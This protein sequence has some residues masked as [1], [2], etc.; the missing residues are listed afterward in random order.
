MLDKIRRFLTGDF[1]I[2]AARYV[3]AILLTLLLGS[4]LIMAYGES[5]LTAIHYIIKGSFGSK[6]SIGSTIRY[7]TPC[8]LLAT[9]AA[10][11]F[12]S[13]V[14]N[15]GLE[16]QLYF[17]SLVAAVV[18]YN[19]HLP[20]GIHLVVC[21]L[22]GAL[23]GVIYAL[24]PA[25]LKLLI[26]VDEMVSTLML[27]FIAVSMTDYIV[28][29][30]IIGGNV[31]ES[32]S[33][34]VVTPTIDA[35]AKLPTLIKGITSNYGF[36]IAIVI[37]VIVYILYKYTVLGYE[38]KQ[39]G[40]NIKFAKLGGVNTNKTFLIIFIVSGFIAGLCGA[41]EVTGSYG[42]FLSGYASNM[43]WNGIMIAH[44]ANR[45]PLT[46]IIVSL[47]WGA[48]QAGALTME[49]QTSLNKLTVYIVQML[50]VLFISVDYKSIFDNIKNRARERKIAK[51]KE[52]A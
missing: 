4:V 27:N 28:L 38:L 48:L 7:M 46:I 40:E 20:A 22:A 30:K 47:I 17:G 10:V 32:G 45:N 13:G 33:T 19:F 8:V 9:A 34:A 35:T 3:I 37:A 29:W 49:R 26:N 12:K 21:L 52:I 44:I 25:F 39:V 18:G 6:M 41:I 14:L 2:S 23:A 36:F 1:K 15:M 42:K 31:S 16:G 5:P 11:A 24:I 51:S 43:A 50:F